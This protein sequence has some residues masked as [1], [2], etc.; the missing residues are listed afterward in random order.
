MPAGGVRTGASTSG[1]GNSLKLTASSASRYQNVNA[2]TYDPESAIQRVWT[3]GYFEAS[4]KWT[5]GQGAWPAFWLFSQAQALA[6]TSA[7]LL[8]AEIDIFEGQGS[9]PTYVNNAL[10]SNSGSGFGVPDVQAPDSHWKDA[11][12]GALSGAF[13]TYAALWTPTEVT[14]YLNSIQTNT[15]P[16]FEQTDQAMFLILTM[17][18]GGWYGSTDRTTPAELTTEVDWVRV[19]QPV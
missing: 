3:E 5:G 18:T 16:P 15:C 2:A 10:H 17:S 6:E 1:D 14:W 4:I 11:G 13:N 8:C 12:Q 9:Q 7:R 19:W